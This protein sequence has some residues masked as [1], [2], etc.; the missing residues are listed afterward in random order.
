MTFWNTRTGLSLLA[1]LLCLVLIT[2]TIQE[3]DRMRATAVQQEGANAE[4]GADLYEQHCRKCHGGRGEGVGQ[5]GPALSNRHF[6]TER[7]SEVG[8]LDSLDEYIVATTAHGRMMA[9]RPLYAGNGL[10]AVMSP[11]LIRYGGPL[12]EDQIRSL[13]RFVMNWE[14]TA[15][16]KVKLKSID[17]PPSDFSDPQTVREGMQVFHTHCA[18]CHAIKGKKDPQA[19]GPSLDGI[20]RTAGNRLSKVSA[21]DYIRQSVLI[22]DAFIVEGF[23]QEVE[24]QS[25]CGAVLPE[26]QLQSIIAFLLQQYD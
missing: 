8:W 14:A 10:T 7:K 2:L 16:G 15:L 6:F 23:S 11:W 13:T 24:M 5:L 18:S 3:D 4:I 22:P 26:D 9:T 21:A 19:T 20:A 25:S 1:S 17:L 12:R